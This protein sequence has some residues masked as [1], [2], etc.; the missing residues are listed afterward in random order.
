MPVTLS[1]MNLRP[2]VKNN[3]NTLKS[4]LISV[5]YA[6][7]APRSWLIFFGQVSTSTEMSWLWLLISALSNDLRRSWNKCL[8]IWKTSNQ[9]ILSLWGNR[10]GLGLTDD[11]GGGSTVFTHAIFLLELISESVHSPEGHFCTSNKFWGCVEVVM[12]IMPFI[13]TVSTEQVI[14]G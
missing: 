7:A 3:W 10:A 13:P 12:N 5:V 11:M 2:F 9:S 4:W 1:Q 8:R 14:G 6:K